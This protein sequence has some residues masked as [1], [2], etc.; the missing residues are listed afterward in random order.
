MLNNVV[1]AGG[2]T[3]IP[4]FKERVMGEIHSHFYKEKSFDIHVAAEN[5]R[6]IATWIGGSMLASMSTF[7]DLFFTKNDLKEQGDRLFPKIF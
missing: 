4:G 7:K 2:T 6:N 5:Y 1:L 3:M